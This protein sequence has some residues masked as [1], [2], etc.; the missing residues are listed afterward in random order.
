MYFG[1]KFLFEVVGY[2]DYMLPN[3]TN[4]ETITI[5]ITSPANLP[6]KKQAA[7]IY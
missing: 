2:N 5:Y 7:S 4:F 1:E 6:L 3:T